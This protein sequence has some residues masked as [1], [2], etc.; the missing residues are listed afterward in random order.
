M[1]IS[2]AWLPSRVKPASPPVPHTSAPIQSGGPA[3]RTPEKS[4]PGTRGSTVP[5]ICPSTFLTSLGFTDAAR[6]RTTAQPRRGWGSGRSTSAS[7]AAGSPKARNCN[8]RIRN[9]SLRRMGLACRAWAPLRNWRLRHCRDAGFQ[10]KVVIEPILA[11]IFAELADHSLISR[12][13]R[14]RIDN[15]VP[16]PEH[17]SNQGFII[18]RRYDDMDVSRTV[19]LPL[20]ESHQFAYRPVCRHGVGRRHQTHQVERACLVG[21]E[22]TAEVVVGLVLVLILV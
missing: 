18:R 2:S 17:L 22:L 10:L 15:V 16:L 20:G 6:I 13:N 14:V 8:A 4:R 1:A 11:V 7:F 21:L 5:S 12:E 19:G 9:A 3:S